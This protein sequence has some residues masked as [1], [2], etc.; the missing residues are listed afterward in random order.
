MADKR[1]IKWFLDFMYTDFQQL[2][3][4][5]FFQKLIELN[6][7][8][9]NPLDAGAWM[10]DK[11]GYRL[12]T[13]ELANG[14]REFFLSKI[15]PRILEADNRLS[16]TM[17]NPIV[18]TEKD[19]VGESEVGDILFPTH[20]DLQLQSVLVTN[21]CVKADDME[22]LGRGYRRGYTG[23]IET[24]RIRTSVVTDFDVNGLIFQLLF[25]LDGLS[26]SDLGLCQAEGCQKWFVRMDRKKKFFCGP[27]C[28]SRQGQREHRAELQKDPEEYKKYREGA[29]E[30][31]A[32]S[33]RRKILEDTPGAKVGKKLS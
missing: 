5:Q 22:P 7:I 9:G 32:K 1:R 33:Y 15:T 19:K 20:F 16:S 31:A 12:N 4:D 24:V 26:V 2:E 11:A 3:W 30:R 10:E 28:A 23:G 17:G 25:A 29:K 18:A 21:F 14:L 8:L 13:A 6:K 27:R